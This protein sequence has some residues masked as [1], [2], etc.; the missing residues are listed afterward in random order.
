MRV[1]LTIACVAVADE[2]MAEANKAAIAKAPLPHLPSF[3]PGRYRRK[4]AFQ[5]SNPAKKSS[6][7]VLSPRFLTSGVSRRRRTFFFSSLAGT[8]P[9]ISQNGRSDGDTL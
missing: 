1:V 7:A 2:L 4:A 8:W 6:N 3:S 5:P 9:V